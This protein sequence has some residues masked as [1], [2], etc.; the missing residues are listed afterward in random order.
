VGE[1]E[2]DGEEL[3]DSGGGLCGCFCDYHY[4][5]DLWEEDEG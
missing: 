5:A 4:L 2:W 3:W 1:G